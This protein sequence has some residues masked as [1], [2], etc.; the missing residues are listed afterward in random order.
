MVPCKHQQLSNDY[1]N[2]KHICFFCSFQ[3]VPENP[4]RTILNRILLNFIFL[5][6]YSS[7]FCTVLLV[8]LQ[9]FLTKKC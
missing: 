7:L 6:V 1:Y 2:C 9:N 4:T 8:P 5:R 3:T